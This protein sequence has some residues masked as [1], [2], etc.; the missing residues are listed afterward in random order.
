MNHRP[1]RWDLGHFAPSAWPTKRGFE[2]WVGLTC[3]GYADYF[4]HKQNAYMQDNGAVAV[5]VIDL[6]HDFMDVDKTEVDF[7][8]SEE[9]HDRSENSVSYDTK[10]KT[11][12][13]SVSKESGSP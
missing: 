1:I 4:T 8:H 9:G 7:F 3:Y 10:I 12:G 6:H 13:S 5:E 2:S 11:I